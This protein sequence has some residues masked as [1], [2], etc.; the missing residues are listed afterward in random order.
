[1]TTALTFI[2]KWIYLKS[3]LLDGMRFKFVALLIFFGSLGLFHG[4]TSTDEIEL[5]DVPEEILDNN[6]YEERKMDSLLNSI[7]ETDDVIFPKTFPENYKNKYKSEE[8]DYTATKPKESIWDKIQRAFGELLESIFGKIDS[9]KPFDFAKNALYFLAVVIIGFVLYFLIKFLISKEGSFFFGKKNKKINIETQELH[10]N[11]HE[12]NFMDS[13]KDYE[14]NRDFRYAVRY[15]FLWILK[16]LADKNIIEW[17][18]K[19]TNRDYMTE[20]KE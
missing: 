20:I 11:I 14:R 17:N 15:Q 1:M 5:D 4:Q 7:K 9:S 10:E 19:K 12:I 6:T 8:F 3:K 18:P 2:E 13:I 16:I